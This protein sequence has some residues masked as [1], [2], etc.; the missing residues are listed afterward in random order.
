M[1]DTKTQILYDFI[2]KGEEQSNPI[3]GDRTQNIG[4]VL[5]RN[6]LNYNIKVKGKNLQKVIIS[7]I[8][9]PTHSIKGDNL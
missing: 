5:G 4:F 1:S 7:A 9:K 8:F 3:Y 6:I 2:Y